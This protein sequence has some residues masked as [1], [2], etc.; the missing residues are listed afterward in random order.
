MHP[1]FLEL[2]DYLG[3]AFSPNWCEPGDEKAAQDRA[4]FEGTD[5]E[6][7]ASTHVFAYQ[8]IAL[9]VMGIH[10]PYLARLLERSENRWGL[11]VLD[12]G[13]GGGQVGIG[14]HYLGFKVSFAD[15]PSRSLMWLMWRLRKQRLDLPVY[16]ISPDIEIPHH[17][18]VLCF[19]VLEHLHEATREATLIRLG[20]LGSIVFVNLVRDEHGIKD[21]HIPL[22][23]EAI[24]AFVRERWDCEAE[25]FYPDANG[26]PRQRLL[27]YGNRKVS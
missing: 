10:R 16:A 25:D 11:S 26:I 19:D 7:T 8:N 1:S 21:V 13:A 3:S 23:F 22:D 4:E 17:H 15:I 2:Q 27:I 24:T 6:W 9:A 12:Y 20:E 14:L 5:E 18:V